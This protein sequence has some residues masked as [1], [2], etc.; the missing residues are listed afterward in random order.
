MAAVAAGTPAPRRTAWAEGADR[1]RAAATTE[2]GRL[3]IIGAALAAL[4][5]AFGAVTAWQISERSSAAQGVTNSSEPLSADAAEI[6]R[7]LAAANTTEAGGFLV[8]GVEPAAVRQRYQNDIN[9][10]A[11][12]IAEAAASSQG[13]SASQADV[14]KLS[15]Q[16]PVY[17]G[18]VETART[19]NR[20]GLPLGGAYLRYANQQMSDILLPT[21]QHLY[22]LQSARL[23]QD[24]ASAESLPWGAW[25]LGVLALGALVWAQRRTYRRTNRVFNPG[26][27]AG[28]TAAGALLVWLVAAHTV[29]REDLAD[30]WDHGAKSLQVLSQAR[31]DSLQARG[32][33][34]LT[35]V[36]RGAGASYETNYQDEMAALDGTQVGKAPGGLLAQAL[37]LADDPAG[38]APVQAAAADVAQWSSRHE[39]ANSADTAGNYD[40]AVAD[41]IIGATDATGKQVNPTATTEYSFDAVDSSL[42]DALDHEGA[43]FQKASGDGRRALTGLSIGAAVLALL[44]AAGSILG[45]G[46][47]LSEYR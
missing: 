39:V 45:V 46:R 8:G 4:I 15:T 26:M 24:Y 43:E 20:Q 32:N 21:A 17:T 3:R 7:S 19:D 38:R 25:A 47:R 42:Q 18:L 2:P 31:I 12:L 30:S 44:G 9:T 16:L 6:Y 40:T 5:L 13:S 37:A 35:L 29:A 34:N 36:A 22:R 11:Q 41:V 1:I 14:Q 23:Q 10:A 28:T 27:L 33:E